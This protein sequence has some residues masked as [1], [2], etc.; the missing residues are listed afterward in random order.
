M[1]RDVLGVYEGYREHY[2]IWLQ[3]ILFPP[4]LSS[5][6]RLCDASLDVIDDQRFY[7]T[8]CVKHNS[9]DVFF[10][11]AVCSH[12]MRCLTVVKHYRF[13][14]GGGP[15]QRPER[16]RQN[17]RRSQISVVTYAFDG[18]PKGLPE[19]PSLDTLGNV[20]IRHRH[21]WVSESPS[22]QYCIPHIVSGDTLNQL[23]PVP[24]VPIPASANSH[25]HFFP[26]NTFDFNY[27]GN[28]P[29]SRT[30]L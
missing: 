19:W 5:V 16:Q 11:L 15:L 18:T 6:L 13:L 9:E 12:C 3:V 25:C 28:L 2:T 26:S 7:S 23:I 14:L 10:L 27:L 24:E 4:V 8:F 30:Q 29:F 20:N 1:V 22:P 21:F 17:D